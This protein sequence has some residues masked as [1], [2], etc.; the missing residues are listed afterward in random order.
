MSVKS[1]LGID[2]IDLAIH[3]GVTVCLLGFVGVS[4]GPE[5]LFPVITMGSIIALAVRRKMAMRRGLLDPR[6]E[7][8]RLAEVE[9]RVHY[10]EGLQDRVIEL[11]ERLDFAERLLAQ[12]QNEKLP[13]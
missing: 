12:R 2:A 4:N 8:E 7:A 9:E 3:A 10:L 11:E 6:Q 1:W 5:G 13:R